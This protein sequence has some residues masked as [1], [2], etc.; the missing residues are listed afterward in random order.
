M[1]RKPMLVQVYLVLLAGV[2]A[3]AQPAAAPKSIFATVNNIDP[4]THEIVIKADAGGEMT[5]KL[6]AKVN[7]RKVALGEKDL[8]NATVITFNDIAKGDRVMA[9]GKVA[10]DNKTIEANLIVVMSQADVAKK[11]EADRADWEK[12]GVNGLVTAVAADKI[13]M[14][15]RTLAGTKN[16]DVVLAPKADVRRYTTDSVKFEEAVPSSLAEVKVG[17]QVRARGDKNEDGSQ[18]TAEEV[19]SGTFRTIAAIVVSVNAAENMMT[20][21]D[22]D[23]KKTVVIKVNPAESTIKR[24]P[25][26]M[27]Q[28]IARRVH[29][30]AA[31][32]A[33][34]GRGAAVPGGRGGA[35]GA[36]GAGGGM[37]GG[38]GPGGPGGGDF[39]QM[40]ER[41]PAITL[42]DLKAGEPIVVASTVG[43]AS[44]H[45]MAITMLAGV[46][47]ILRSPGKPEMTLGGWS[48]G[49]M[50]GEVP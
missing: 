36:P 43:K 15:M 48:L 10:D 49:G 18:M 38:R 40:L 9:R 1:N 12:R 3:L 25:D 45:I 2:L 14:K 26:V 6:A 19:V 7:F 47:P 5:V 20:V 32:A 21:K 50:G 13:T 35:P 22:L 41:V 11:Q 42:A 44:D 34:A 8:T 4:A 31:G 30:E 16:I 37:G 23:S 28:M 39:Q 17:D 29:P 46:E 33:G 27:A 24:L